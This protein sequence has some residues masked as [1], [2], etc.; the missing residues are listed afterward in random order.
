MVSARIRQM[1]RVAAAAMS[2]FAEHGRQA[3]RP[4]ARVG[5]VDSGAHSD[6]GVLN[7]GVDVAVRVL[8]ESGGVRLGTVP[9]GCSW[10]S[11]G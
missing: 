3:W 10:L 8:S 5:C 9:G 1:P 6:S 7:R 4:A 2:L 11:G